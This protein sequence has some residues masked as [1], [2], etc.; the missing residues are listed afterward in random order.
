MLAECRPYEHQH[1]S[2]DDQLSEKHVL[3]KR[4]AVTLHAPRTVY[5]YSLLSRT[6]RCLLTEDHSS[7]LKVTMI[8]V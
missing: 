3:R 5:Y 2:R 1:K 8:V 7:E 6:A 4:K